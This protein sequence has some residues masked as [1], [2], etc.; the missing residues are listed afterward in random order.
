MG[1]IVRH[2]SSIIEIQLL[3]KFMERRKTMK[4]IHIEDIDNLNFWT[5]YFGC[6]YPNSYVLRSLDIIYAK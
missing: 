2:K 4:T 6:S 1:W 3:N 5:S